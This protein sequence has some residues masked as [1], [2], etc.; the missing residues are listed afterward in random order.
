[1][2][3][4]MRCWSITTRRINRKAKVSSSTPMRYL[5]RL[6]TEMVCSSVSITICHGVRISAACPLASNEASEDEKVYLINEKNIV[7]LSHSIVFST[8]SFVVSI[9]LGS[10]Y[11]H[12]YSKGNT[13][14][15]YREIHNVLPLH[16]SDSIPTPNKHVHS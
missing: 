14:W 13:H 3:A 9:F 8:W 5:L 10:L 4:P 12:Y 1:M 2:S 11:F 15:I 6:L 16:Q 7:I